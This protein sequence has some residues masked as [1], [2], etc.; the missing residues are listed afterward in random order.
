[1][2]A[3]AHGAESLYTPLANPV[4]TMA[5]LRGAELLAGALDHPAEE[6]DRAALALGSLLCAYALDSAGFALHHVVCQTLVGCSGRPTR[7]PTRRCSP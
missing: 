6:R 7:R 4:A 2:N 3:L 1:M 5:A